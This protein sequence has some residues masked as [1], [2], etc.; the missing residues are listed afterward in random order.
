MPAANAVEAAWSMVGLHSS[1]PAT[2]YLSTWARVPAFEIGMLE[3]DLYEER[4]LIRM[5]GMRRT[6][7]VVPTEMVPVLHHSSTAPLIEPERRRHIKMIEAGGITTDGEKWTDRASK[8][9]LDAL[10]E[11]GE[12]TASELVA[13]IPDLA[14]KITFY[15]K[16]GSLLSVAGMSTRTL[17]L[18]ATEG[19]VV[20]ARPLGSWISSQYRWARMGDWL[21]HPL[22]GMD[23][24]Q[25][26]DKLI[27]AWLLAF[28]PGTELDIKW[29]TGWPV[30]KVRSALQS[31]GAIEV[32]IDGGSG[33][34]HPDD[35]EPFG[36]PEPWVAFLPGLDPTTMGWKER[37]WYLGDL[38]DSLFD[39]NG[40][41]GPTVWVDGRVVGGWAQRSGGEVVYELMTDVGSEPATEVERRAAEL[42]DWLGGI[43]VIARF[44][45]PHV[46]RLTG[47]H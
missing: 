11:A 5:L 47:D 26:R 6:M 24:D 16:D 9:V 3:D 19:K 32:G 44:K 29:W 35:T 38:G 42:E 36:P 10:A 2:V 27:S 7:W 31:L 21:G 41:A 37:D 33:Y 8:A 40:N 18:L 4:T 22:P 45:S 12:A 1:D 15:K 28:G 17:F 34:L 43:T 30:R 23:P 25:A 39:R 13:G 14:E 20:R 46:N